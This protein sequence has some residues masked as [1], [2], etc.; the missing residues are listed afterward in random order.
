MAMTPDDMLSAMKSKVSSLT[1]EIEELELKIQEYNAKLDNAIE[2]RKKAGESVSQM[3]SMMETIANQWG[4][5]SQKE[6]PK[7]R[8]SKKTTPTP[9][10]TPAPAPAPTP[11][12]TPAPAPVP[13][14]ENVREEEG[15][16]ASDSADEVIEVTQDGVRYVVFLD[17]NEVAEED[18]A[19]ETIIGKWDPKATKVI[20]NA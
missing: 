7:K 2:T 13:E 10:P 6:A 5:G 16:P 15:D 11:A 19:E 14:V 20:L 12:P 18:D 1:D 3:M 9:A 17:T 8:V 4:L